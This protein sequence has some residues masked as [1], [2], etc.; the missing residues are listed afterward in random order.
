[1]QVFAFLE[2]FE[3][4]GAFCGIQSNWCLAGGKQSYPHVRVCCS[5]CAS[6]AGP[7]R[8][9]K[10]C[11][12]F[13]EGARESLEGGRAGALQ[14]ANTVSYSHLSPRG[15]FITNNYVRLTL[16]LLEPWQTAD[17]RRL[18]RFFESSQNIRGSSAVPQAL[19]VLH[20]VGCW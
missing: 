18:I 6:A 12:L 8:W 17:K 19:A 16:Y 13:G 4:N 2:F 7:G 3:N 10:S 5:L 1:M 14:S 15:N 9:A 11:Q 20:E